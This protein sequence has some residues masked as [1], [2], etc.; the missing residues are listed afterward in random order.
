MALVRLL[1]SI[2]AVG[3]FV[4]C[5]G[6]GG[7]TPESPSAAPSPSAS[8]GSPLPEG[9]PPDSAAIRFRAS[10]G[11]RLAGRLFGSGDVGVVLAHQ[12]DNDQRAWFDFA[13]QLSEAGYAALTFD[14]RGYCPGGLGGCSA[15]GELQETWSDVLGAVRLLREQGAS[16][17]WL[18]GASV[19]GDACLVAAATGAPGIA[20]VITVS[21]PSFIGAYDIRR[22]TMARIATPKLF[23]AGR[24]D[25]DAPSSARTFYRLSSQPKRLLLLNTAQHGTDLLRFGFASEEIQQRV[26]DAIIDQL[27]VP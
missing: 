13:A 18:I 9:P 24:L 12:I 16:R 15:N 1:A 20:G 19:G 7:S 17:V 14:F 6:G 11:T 4:G 27:P 10:D 21:T 5:S 8:P 22:T 23:I 26:R 3:L 2:V 25:G